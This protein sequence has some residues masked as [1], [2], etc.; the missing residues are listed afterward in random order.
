MAQRKLL[1]IFFVMW[2]LTGSRFYA[3]K[4]QDN[5][6][7]GTITD[8]HS[9]RPIAGASVQL[10]PE[11]QGE[12]YITQSKSDGRFEFHKIPNGEYL[13]SAVRSGYLLAEF[14]K[15]RSSDPAVA[16]H[17]SSSSTMPEIQLT[18]VSAGAIFGTAVDVKGEPVPA[19]TV[20]AL[21]ETYAEGERAL[22]VVQTVI[23]DDLGNYRLFSLPPGR[24][25][26]S[27]VLPS[28]ALAPSYY[29]NA[30]DIRFARPVDLSAGSTAGGIN[31]TSNFVSG[32][33]IQG[34]VSFTG[35][36]ADVIIVPRLPMT[37]SSV[38]ASVSVDRINGTFVIPNVFPGDYFLI[39]QSDGQ[40]VQLPLEVGSS[41]ISPIQIT[42][43][44]AVEFRV[45]VS[46][47][48]AS[49][50]SANTLL[51][52]RSDQTRID[53]FLIGDFT[54]TDRSSR[55]SLIPGDYQILNGGGKSNEYIQ[56]VRLG[57]SDVMR[58][59]L[60]VDSSSGGIIEIVMGSHPG[61]LSGVV[62]DSTGKPVTNVMV[63]L[64]PNS[65]N[66]KRIDLFKSVRTDAHGRF[67][68]SNIPPGDYAVFSWE[69]VEPTAWLNS[70]FLS[71]YEKS[72]RPVHIDADAKL[73]IEIR[74]IPEQD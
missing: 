57:I 66:R 22:R 53:E 33:T 65:A 31:I 51:R 10:T 52:I 58:D 11:T 64:S 38:P 27:V 24:Y 71:Q 59:G 29:P 1:I 55:L 34:N 35:N 74:V 73:N 7:S 37:P 13:L 8:R 61:R 62:S 45:H 15:K 49:A 47:D 70:E 69:D 56:S 17:I 19:V 44:R 39:A 67:E 25:Y 46:S 42:I 48:A 40:R 60:H 23:T 30:S 5:V 26:V 4:P 54:G 18:M 16:L 6:V 32:I 14:E 20:R 36:A 72:G 68:I 43:P 28:N 12:P 41:A 9:H 50:E 3:Q 2:A 21:R 63:V